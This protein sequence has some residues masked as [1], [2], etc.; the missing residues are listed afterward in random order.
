MALF[1]LAFAAPEPEP[2]LAYAASPVVAAAP[3][4]V[5]AAPSGA[6]YT[7]RYYSAPAAVVVG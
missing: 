5:A 3:A 6:I 2:L 4:V 7:A 1:A